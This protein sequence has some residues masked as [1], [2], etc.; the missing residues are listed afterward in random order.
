MLTGDRNKNNDCKKGNFLVSITGQNAGTWVELTKPIPGLKPLKDGSCFEVMKDTLVFLTKGNKTFD[1]YRL[2]TNQDS[3]VKMAF[4]PAG[5]ASKPVKKGAKMIGDGARYIYLVKGGNT[6]EFYR[7]DI[8]RDTWWSLP[9]VPLG[10]GKK[11]KDGTGM[12]YCEKLGESFIYLLKG[13]KTQ[14]FYRYRI[15]ADSWEKMPDAPRGTQKPGFKKGSDIVCD[16]ENKIIYCLKDR[17]NEIFAY[18]VNSDTWLVK[19][20]ANMPLI[21]PLSGKKKKVKDGSALCLVSPE[22]VYCLKGGNTCEFWLFKPLEGDSGKWFGLALLP[23]IGTDGKK[24]RVKDG[25]DLVAVTYRNQT[26]LLAIKG[27]KTDKIW[28]WTDS[29]FALAQVIGSQ[30]SIKNNI[31]SSDAAFITTKLEVKP[32]PISEVALIKFALPKATSPSRTVIK[33]YNVMGKMVFEHTTMKRTGMIVL[34]T[35]KLPAGVYLLKFGA[36]DFQATKKLIISR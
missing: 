27:N 5:A 26:A 17:T 34:D 18:D 6:T 28:K 29:L 11:V 20:L 33:L 21:H 15:A 12:A 24:K 14:E 4:V 36:S 2:N 10:S 1:F 23:E 30:A 8:S 22:M 7:Y 25:G 19:K 32:N 13:A 35:K 9:A 16:Q 31:N 3:W